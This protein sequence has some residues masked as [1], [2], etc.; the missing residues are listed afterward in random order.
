MK[1]ML[2]RGVLFSIHGW[3]PFPSTTQYTS[4]IAAIS[5]LLHPQNHWPYD[6]FA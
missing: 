2:Q 3:P 6:H 5:T 1:P 4:G